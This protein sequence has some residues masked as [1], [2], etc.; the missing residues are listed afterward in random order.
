MQEEARSRGFLKFWFVGVI[1]VAALL[2]VFVGR[3]AEE[4]GWDAYWRLM[5][6]GAETR[7]TIVRTLPGSDCLAEYSF[8]VAGRS[9]TGTGRQCKVRVGQTVTVT[10]LIADP[11]HS[12][13]GHAGQRLADE[14]VSFFF[15][16]FSFPSLS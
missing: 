11:A 16:G 8:S 1:G 14:V 3:T 10:Y 13:L 6:S 5:R 12:C 4:Q 7:A 9:Y 2:A 15:G